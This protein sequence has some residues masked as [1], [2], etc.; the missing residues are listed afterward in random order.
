MPADPDAVAAA[1][2]LAKAQIEKR[3]QEIEATSAAGGSQESTVDR[4]E[5]DARF[6]EG[7]EALR[8]GKFKF[9]ERVFRAPPIEE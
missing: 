2:G 5:L 3:L 9:A 7:I 1:T 8:S 6:A 4:A